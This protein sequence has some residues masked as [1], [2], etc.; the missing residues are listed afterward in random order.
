MREYDPEARVSPAH[1]SLPRNLIVSR[2]FRALVDSMLQSSATFR[3]Q[4]RRIAAAPDL[5]VRIELVSH[6]LPH[7]MRAR[8]R[9]IARAA[10][11]VAAVEIPALDDA[12]ELIGHELEHVIEH[13]D[14]VDLTSHAARRDATVEASWAH[15][16]FETMRARHVG[17]VVAQE[18]RQHT[19]DR[20]ADLGIHASYSSPRRR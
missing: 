3:Q 9:L 1:A 8:T 15:G 14:G 7:G 13:L 17:L 6:N 18:V 4:C 19:A 12:V 16:T 2:H 10:N 11:R 5:T 20:R